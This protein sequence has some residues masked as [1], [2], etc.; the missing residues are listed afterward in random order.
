MYVKINSLVAVAEIESTLTRNI[1][2]EKIRSRVVVA[3]LSYFIGKK[4]K[5]SPSISKKVKG[6]Y[7]IYMR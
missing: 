2:K 3:L 1:M 7:R 5:K 6:V 4:E